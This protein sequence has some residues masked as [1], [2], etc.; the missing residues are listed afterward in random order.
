MSSQ[1]NQ[2]TLT[3]PSAG[4][5]I[6]PLENGLCTEMAEIAKTEKSLKNQITAR[7]NFLVFEM[8]D[9]SGFIDITAVRDEEGTYLLKG[10]LCTNY[11]NSWFL[12]CEPPL[13]SENFILLTLIAF[14]NLFH[15][16]V[17]YSF[18]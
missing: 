6:Y 18:I 13:L 12:F 7:V 17:L 9:M 4:V 16:I 15:T 11:Q 14:A 8:T 5:F 2:E 3:A 1:K 10:M